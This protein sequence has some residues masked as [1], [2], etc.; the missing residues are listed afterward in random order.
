MIKLKITT[1][2][3]Y[4]ETKKKLHSKREHPKESYDSVIKRIL[5]REKI[6]SMEEMFKI[7]DKLKQKKVY[8]T[9]EVIELT[10]KLRGKR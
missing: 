5:E 1:I 4:E 2:Q 9:K 6:P 10:H 7:G 3:L 8:T